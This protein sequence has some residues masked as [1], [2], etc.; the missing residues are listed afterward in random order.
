MSIHEINPIFHRWL[1]KSINEE[2]IIYYEFSD[3]KNLQPIGN[4]SFGKV[5]R[6]NWKNSDTIFAIKKFNNDKTTLKGVVNE[7]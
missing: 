3:F 2:F 7:V 1:E 4:G 6:A 5:L